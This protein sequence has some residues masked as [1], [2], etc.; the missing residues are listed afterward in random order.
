MSIPGNEGRVKCVKTSPADRPEAESHAMPQVLTTHVMT[1]IR[2]YSRV[3][4]DGRES[5]AVLLMRTYERLVRAALPRKTSEVD[6]IAD[7]F[8]LRFPSPAEAV[9]TAM[10]IADSFARH[11][12]THPEVRLPVS[13][14]IDTGESVSRGSHFVGSA[15]VLANRLCHRA[16]PG[17]ILLSETVFALL[18]TTKIGPMRDLGVWTPPEANHA[19]HVYEAR[20][21]DAQPDGSRDV[22]RFLKALLFEDI[23]SSTATSANLG[24]QRWRQ[25][26][27]QHHAIVR[28]ELRR[29]RGTEIDTAGDGFYAAFDAPSEAID[30]AFAIRDRVRDLGIAVRAGVHAGECEVVAGKIGGMSVTIGARVGAQAGAGEILVSQTVKDLLMGAGYAFADGR[31]S[32]LKG[33]PGEWIVYTVAAP[34]PLAS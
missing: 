2:G 9:R 18:R 24:D 32:G 7:S 1:D 26:V 31:P 3:I 14:G 16:R 19:I 34:P 11:N 29:H 23:V 12:D 21:P 5:Q 13:F 27:E 8:H 15:P 6:H 28:D 20:S 10:T 33:V 17:Q 4:L 30:C 25:L 22:E